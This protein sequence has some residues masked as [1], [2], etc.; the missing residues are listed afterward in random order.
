MLGYLGFAVHIEDGEAGEY[1]EREL[2]AF[3]LH[4]EDRNLLIGKRGDRLEDIQYLLN[5][6][7]HERTGGEAP[8]VR[9]DIEHYR[10][11]REAELVEKVKAFAERVRAT[12]KPVKLNPMNSYYRRIVHHAFKDDPEIR[13]WSPND[14]NRVKSITLMR[15]PKPREEGAGP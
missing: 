15:R 11:M 12:G 5:R 8:R 14:R 1:G 10:T 13:S 3:Q 2:I 4:T 6:L 7:L 9:V